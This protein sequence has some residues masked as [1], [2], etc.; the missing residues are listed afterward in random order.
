MVST[1]NIICKPE[2][3]SV[4]SYN[5]EEICDFLSKIHPNGNFELAASLPGGGLLSVICSMA[6]AG[7]AFQNLY[8][9]AQDAIGFFC[10]LNPT[11]KLE[12]LQPKRNRLSAADIA[13]RKHLVVDIDGCKSG[14]TPEDRERLRSASVELAK[15]IA[16]D[17]TR[18]GWAEPV[19][20][21]SG[22]GA[23]M[24]YHINEPTESDLVLRTLK[25]LAAK[26]DT[27]E[28]HIDTAVADANRIGRLPGTWNCKK[29]YP[30]DEHRMAK[31]VSAPPADPLDG[32]FHLVKVPHDALEALAKDIPAAETAPKKGDKIAAGVTELN[33]EQH[34]ERFVAYLQ[35]GAPP[36][37]QGSRNSTIA[38]VAAKAGDFGLN[39]AELIES[40]MIEHWFN[41]EGNDDIDDMGDEVSRTINSALRS[42][43]S[44]IG[45]DTAEAVLSMFDD[46]KVEAVST[47]KEAAEGGEKPEA[48]GQAPDLTKFNAALK[49]FDD[50][51]GVPAPPTEWFIPG[52]LTAEAD[53]VLWVGAGGSGK[54][55]L[56]TQLSQTLVQG[57]VFPLENGSVSGFPVRTTINGEPVKVAYVSAEEPTKK[58]HQR[59]EH[60]IKAIPTRERGRRYLLNIYEA[61][62]KLFHLDSNRDMVGGA[63]WEAFKAGLVS[64]GVNVLFI[65]NLSNL[66]SGDENIRRTVST[67]CDLLYELNKLGIKVILLAH[68]NKA[69][70]VSGS[71]GWLNQADQV[72]LTSAKGIKE[73]RR[74]K[75]EILK[76]NDGSPGDTIYTV[77]D[78]SCWCHRVIT[79]EEYKTVQAP[80]SDDT[81]EAATEAVMTALREAKDR[82]TNG[83][84][85]SDALSWGVLR[86][87]K[88]DA[89][90]GFGE[91]VIKG[92]IDNLVFDSVIEE[93]TVPTKNTKKGMYG[94]MIK[95]YRL[96]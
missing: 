19:I 43:Q 96:T 62:L 73:N 6:K 92:V 22:N 81:M 24:W 8:N 58:H 17:L 10:G 50:F 41:R 11:S 42:R 69:G 52:L 27:E 18:E 47:S 33:T 30:S 77:F 64:K 70:Y 80:C 21:H 94:K 44:E 40:L 20:V 36:L 68:T 13:R 75:T 66:M 3:S 48:A 84:A 45:C 49:S 82:F 35:Q 86:R 46:G 74:F 89:D 57:G 15:R 38:L 53:F 14:A 16:D 85:D 25:A 39:D 63:D 23:Q 78:V 88:D 59:Y 32:D 34:K 51:E 26:Y 1:N 67:F 60:Q 72:W 87:L 31:V 7:E 91:K 56:T 79:E 55:T 76:N 29:D 5:L 54:T 93:T 61:G 28:L 12:R 71:S 95:A 37:V 65:D 4:S 9:A 2:K 83:E 90:D